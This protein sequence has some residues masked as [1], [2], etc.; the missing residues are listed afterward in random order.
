MAPSFPRDARRTLSMEKFATLIGVSRAS[1]YFWLEDITRPS[2]RSMAKVCNA[3]G[4]SLAEGLAQFSP[5]RM[6][7]PTGQKRGD[8][9]VR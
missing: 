9:A 2:E 7:R 8:R 3:L 5:K 4:E 1:V 6:G